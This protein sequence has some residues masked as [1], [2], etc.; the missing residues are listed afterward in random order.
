MSTRPRPSPLRKVSIDEYVYSGDEGDEWSAASWEPSQIISPKLT[1]KASLA[2]QERK[3]HEREQLPL[4]PDDYDRLKD[5]AASEEFQRILVTT[6][7]DTA[8]FSPE[9]RLVCRLLQEAIAMRKKWC[10][11]PPQPLPLVRSESLEK[12]TINGFSGSDE[13]GYDPFYF[14][15]MPPADTDVRIEHEN[16]VFKVYRE[17]ESITSVHSVEEY[18]TDLAAVMK[19]S[20][21]GESKTLCFHRL[22]MLDAKFRMHLMFNLERE[23]VQQKSVPHRD[24]Y[25]VRKVDTHVHHSACMNQKHLLRFIKKKLKTESD[26][27]VY[28]S[29]G[30]VQ[31]LAEVFASLNLTAYDLSVDSLDMQADVRTFHR[32]DRFNLK[33]NP[34]GQTQLRDIFLKSDNYI[35][36]RYLAEITQEV[37]DDLESNK[38]QF[39]EYRI[40]IYGRKKSEWVSLADWF[41]NNNIHSKNV[42]WMIQ[43]PRLY[44]VYK[45]LGLINTFQDMIDNI[46]Q[47]LFEVTRDPSSNP[48]L[49]RLLGQLVGFDSVDDESQPEK[50][51]GGRKLPLPH[52]WDHPDNP[53]YTY[54]SYYLYANIVTLNQYRLARGLNTFSFRPHAGEAGGVDHL[55]S[56]FLLANSI[57][58][59]IVL[60]KTPVLQYLFYLCQIGLALSPL[61]NNRLFLEY[62]KNPFP[63]FFARGLNVSLSTDDPL[64]IHYTKE[65]LL[66]EF[67]VAAQVWKLSPVDL[68]EIARN[69]VLQSNFEHQFKSH[70]LGPQYQS[71]PDPKGNDISKTNV[72]NIRA[73]Y[74]YETLSDELKFLSDGAL[75]TTD[76]MIAWI[77]EH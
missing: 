53:P 21:F 32:F 5:Q 41:N 36:G 16:G 44:Q 6:T 22:Q 77:R 13:P 60:K 50:K 26:V 33:Y 2:Y 63:Q 20:H 35:K 1:R 58:H 75:G 28:Q 55:G 25:N 71:L 24:F 62:E 57:N 19:I 65:P 18:Y 47:P 34:F 46:F 42:R 56:V 68:S 59:G 54:W 49:H 30:Q 38:Y 14:C 43:I 9:S 74:R 73:T 69:S 29:N 45:K 3:I 11:E 10:F 8:L 67:S 66:E 70:W 27:P 51:L 39:S 7:T 15:Q 12:K 17:G 61:S 40:S 4:R 23:I 64:Q 31:T 72:P 52:E 48:N 76:D 37:M